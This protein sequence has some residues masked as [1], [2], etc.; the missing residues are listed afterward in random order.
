MVVVV[1]PAFTHRKQG[2]QGVVPA[3][4][5]SIVGPRAKYVADRVD[6][7][8]A[9]QQKYRG[10]E[11][12]PKKAVPTERCGKENGHGDGWPGGEA[13]KEDELGIL[14]PVRD[15]FLIDGPVLAQHEP[16]QVGLKEAVVNRR[17]YVVWGV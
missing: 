10:H 1:V 15:E 3:V 4:V 7:E 16:G 9:V 17:V 6:G 8:C 13:L 14:Q 12:S 2:K 5:G 11:V